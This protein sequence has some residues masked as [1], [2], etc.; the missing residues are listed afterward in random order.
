MSL[1]VEYGSLDSD[2]V[3]VNLVGRVGRPLTYATV[4]DLVLAARRAVGF[5]SR[6]MSSGIRTRR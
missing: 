4:N 2:Y 6:R 3:F 1:H 5:T